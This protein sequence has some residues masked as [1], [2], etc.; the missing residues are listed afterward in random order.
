MPAC[1]QPK[2]DGMEKV[3]ERDSWNSSYYFAS[4]GVQDSR[5]LKAV[6]HLRIVF[7]IPFRF[8]ST[9]DNYRKNVH[10]FLP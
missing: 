9:G 7:E 6:S 1:S 4:A 3:N 10:D 5:D 8:K 2:C